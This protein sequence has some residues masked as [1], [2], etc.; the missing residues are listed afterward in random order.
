MQTG[1]KGVVLHGD[2]G[3]SVKVQQ[4]GQGGHCTEASE[5]GK[6]GLY[7][8]F[9]R[10]CS[11]AFPLG[12]LSAVYKDQRGRLYHSLSMSFIGV[13]M[14]SF[15]FGMLADLDSGRAP[16]LAAGSRFVIVEAYRH[17]DAD[18]GDGHELL[19]YPSDSCSHGGAAW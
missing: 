17:A 12:I 14:P 7:A 10:W 9:S 18:P 8:R 11:I 15:W 6:A 1:F 4:A 5:Y 3:I 16:R 19:L 2:F 13:S